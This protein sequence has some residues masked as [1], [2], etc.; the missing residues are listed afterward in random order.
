MMNTV[1]L[2]E[3]AQSRDPISNNVI[4]MQKMIFKLKVWNILPK[5][6]RDEVEK[7]R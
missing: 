2:T 4:A 5:V 7:R 6:G 1:E 3:V